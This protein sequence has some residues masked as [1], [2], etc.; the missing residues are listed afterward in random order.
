LAADT[1]F[2]SSPQA[3]DNAMLWRAFWGAV[4]VEA[5][6]TVLFFM[7]LSRYKALCWL[8]ETGETIKDDPSAGGDEEW[9][10]QQQQQEEEGQGGQMH[11]QQHQQQQQGN[12]R[13]ASGEKG[14]E[15]DYDSD[16][17]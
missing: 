3:E 8:Q 1:F 15:D 17:E 6:L 13:Q 10:Q 11:Q 7:A 5:C 12:H 14:D 16:E 2:F 4:G 9:Q